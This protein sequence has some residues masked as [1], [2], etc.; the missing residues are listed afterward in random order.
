MNRMAI[1]STKGGGKTEEQEGQRET[2][3]KGSRE[4]RNGHARGSKKRDTA[5]TPSTRA[6]TSLRTW[7]QPSF[8]LFHSFFFFSFFLISPRLI[9]PLT[10]PT[11]LIHLIILNI[12]SPPSHIHIYPQRHSSFLNR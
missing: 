9:F 2:E 5:D 10:L 6:S 11:L 3:R 1:E 8:V 4:K 7:D 12:P